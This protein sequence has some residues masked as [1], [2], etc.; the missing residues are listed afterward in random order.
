LPRVFARRGSD[1]LLA[2]AM[3]A[4]AAVLLAD[5]ASAFNVD[6]WLAL[7]AGRDL[8]QQGLP[9]H[10]TLTV[11][12]QG[13][14]W[15]DQQWLSQ[16]ASYGLYLIGGLGLL[17]VASV[18]LIASGVAGAVAGAR[19]LGAHPT[20]V[21]AVLPVLFLIVPRREVRTQDFAIPLFVALM[22]LLAAD[23]RSSSRRVYWCLPILALWANLHGTVTLGALLVALRGV[24]VAWERRRTLT[25]SARA[26][27]RPLALA[28]GAPICLLLTP[29][30]LSILGYY[31]TMLVGGTLRHVVTEWQPITSSPA[32]A[33]AF[34]LAA[35]I[36]VWSF[37]R[38]QA[39]TTTW[40]KLALLAL[41][42]GSISVIRNVLFFGLFAVMVLPL[43]LGLGGS[44]SAPTALAPPADR[45]RG[46]INALL[47][48]VAVAA[49][50]IAAVVML[51]RPAST[52]ELSY[53]RPG[54]LTAV[55]RATQADPSLKVFAQDRFAD[56][57]LWRDPALGGRIANDVRYELLTTSQ[58]SGVNSVFSVIGPNWK[59]GARGFG[60]IV[61]DQK[62][63]PDAAQAF[64]R[65]PGSRV[66]YDDGERL[67]ILRSPR[68]TA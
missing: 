26:W 37:G 14:P 51:V 15:V 24:T 11:L 36:A 55:E 49:V 40:E 62:Y 61:L 65:E 64:L 27:A 29:Y 32:T 9:H 50:V 59:Q 41:A 47:S 38:N 1:V 56:W 30:G 46:A 54:V 22:Y 63:A 39:R 18:G 10:E 67:V 16:L 17:G 6:S 4:L 58:I 5:L 33:A 43:S 42:A 48:A 45:R 20:A 19:R 53:Q 13:A 28:L 3:L 44:G 52:I 34:F 12:A 57:L 60:L 2:V 7:V 23:S 66:L 31:K 68:E 21:M 35:T 8:W 25:H